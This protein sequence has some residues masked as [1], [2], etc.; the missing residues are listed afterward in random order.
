MA[1]ESGQDVPFGKPVTV[2]F[3]VVGQNTGKRQAQSGSRERDRVQIETNGKKAAKKNYKKRVADHFNRAAGSYDRAASLQKKVAAKV[4]R[5]LVEDSAPVWVLD[6]GC[7]T[8][9]ETALLQARYPD[10]L[11]VGLDLA[12]AM[13]RFAHLSGAQPAS[14]WCNGDMEKLPFASGSLDLI[15]SSLA[16]QW[17]DLDCVLAEVNRVLRPGGHFVFSSLAAGTMNEL[18]RAWQQVDQQAH[19]NRFAA[20]AEQKAVLEASPLILQSF[21]TQRETLYYPDLPT[22]FRALKA[23]G[24]NTV[25]TGA[26]GLLTAARLKAVERAYE[27]FRQEPGLP[28]SYQVIYGR[29]QK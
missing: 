16:I 28:L 25:R 20:S 23:L 7:G 5:L 26:G 24:V 17:C 10:A 29:L 3:Q 1:T 2:Y 12:M 4:R 8:G 18:D 11:V 22:L 21:C 6:L 9:H 27:Q 19:I 15:Y 13:V 14:R